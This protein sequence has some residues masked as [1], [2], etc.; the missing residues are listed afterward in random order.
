VP[1]EIIKYE[2]S[3]FF[4]NGR[5]QGGQIMEIEFPALEWDT[6]EHES[7]GLIGAIAY[8]QR[9]PVLE[10]TITP[11]G[12]CED[13]ASVAANPN[14]PA[15]IMVRSAFGKYVAGTRVGTVANITIMRG[16]FVNH[17]LGTLSQGE[18]ESEFMMVVDYVKRTHDG[19]L[20]LEYS[21]DANI[22]RTGTTDYFA[23][24]RAI[25]GE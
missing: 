2:T 23:G 8:P 3:S 12:Y 17:D 20:I 25:L 21:V 13:L 10:C 22:Y 1:K 4:V 19:N 7:I 9:M 14:V 11:A 6:T 15:T 16:R 5:S 24:V 18:E